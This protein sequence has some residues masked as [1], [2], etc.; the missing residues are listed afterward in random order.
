MA[1][2]QFTSIDQ[3]TRADWEIV[4][5]YE[6][7][8]LATLPDRLLAMLR[9]M[10]EHEQEHPYQV[11]RLEH[12][13]Q[14]ATRSLRDGAEEEIVVAALLHDIG[15]ELAPYD[16]AEFAASILKPYVSARTH[17]IVQ[18]HDVFQGKYWWDKIDLDPDARDNF[19]GHPWYGYCEAFCRDWDRPSFDPTYDSLPLAHFEPMLR[20]VFARTPFTD[21]T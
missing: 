7:T 16:H 19:L 9:R 8:Q 21:N 10:G 1:K 11:S 6:E 13:L 12:C 15:D 2:A 18:H 17:W 4:A 20:R 14:T 5:R 3:S